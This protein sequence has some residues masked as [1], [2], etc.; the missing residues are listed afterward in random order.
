M[1]LVQIA[2][3]GKKD[4]LHMYRVNGDKKDLEKLLKA[5]EE[6]EATFLN[7]PIIE[8]VRNTEYSVLLELL[9]PLEVAGHA[10]QYNQI[11]LTHDKNT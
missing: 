11:P 6:E 5:L 3:F 4:G 7:D 10:K 9:I 8:N 1:A 2:N